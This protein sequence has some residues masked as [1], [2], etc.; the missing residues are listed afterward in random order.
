MARIEVLLRERAGYVARGLPDRVAAV[1]A[2]L[3]AAGYRIDQRGD[4]VVVESEPGA[5]PVETAAIEAPAKRVR[6]KAD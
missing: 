1:D 4:T 2:A 5:A 6:R 3:A